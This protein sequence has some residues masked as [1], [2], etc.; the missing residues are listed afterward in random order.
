MKNEEFNQVVNEANDINHCKHHSMSESIVTDSNILLEEDDNCDLLEEEEEDLWDWLA[1]EIIAGNVIPVIGENIV[2]EGGNTVRNRIIQSIARIEGIV[3]SPKSYSQLL[4]DENYKKDRSLIYTRI[5]KLF[6]NNQNKFHASSILKRILSIKH[7]PF[8]ITTTTDYIIEQAMREIWESRGRKLETLVFDNNP[9]NIQI[10]GDIK[11]ASGIELPTL[12]YMFGRANDKEHSYVVTDEDMLSFCQSWMTANI[13][14][15]K[16][17]RELGDKFL[18]FLGC[19]YPDWLVR[20]IWFS[21]RRDLDKSGM[22]VDEDAEDSL[23]AFL[24]RVNIKTQ[25]NVE[26]VISA[27]ETRIN[28]KLIQLNRI[29]FDRPQEKTDVFISYSRANEREAKRLYET[30]TAKGLDVWYDR[31]RLEVGDNWSLKIKK[32][33][34]STKFFVVLI[35]ADM[36]NQVNDSKVYRKEWNIAIEHAKG[37]GPNRGFIIPVCIGDESLMYGSDL[38]LPVELTS[39]NAARLQEEQESGRSLNI[40]MEEDY[41]TIAERILKRLNGL[42]KK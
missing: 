36:K 15:E 28:R 5:R 22:L 31:N 17:S 38:D 8:I 27:I 3:S 33:I 42:V 4:Y 32:S 37:M 10:H 14:P 25:R 20:F 30:L 16:L 39:H 1:E 24:N 11:D 40:S 35:S 23:I 19:N 21:M 34:E 26:N 13:R 2:L 12:Y 7:F 9:K 6:E 41:N 18:L 29:K